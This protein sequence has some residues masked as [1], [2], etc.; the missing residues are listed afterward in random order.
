[1]R[2]FKKQ[3]F[4]M[5]VGGIF[6]CLLSLIGVSSCEKNSDSPTPNNNEGN[7]SCTCI[8]PE[9][10][11]SIHNCYSPD[12]VDTISADLRLSVSGKFSTESNPIGDSE[13]EER[14]LQ[15][16][17]PLNQRGGM[18]YTRISY[19]MKTC[20]SIKISLYDKDSVFIADVTDKAHFYYLMYK[21]NDYYQMLIN[22]DKVVLGKVRMGMTI[23]E[24]LE[25]KPFLFVNAHFIFDGLKKDDMKGGKF[26]KTEITLEDGTVLVANSK[27][28]EI[29]S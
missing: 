28:P 7:F 17:D 9:K 3:K 16:I 8:I 15:N 23:D 21:N 1:M 18:A 22:S 25:C 27:G 11:S 29:Y 6:I 2:N 19:T 12:E 4:L 5:S 26:F 10:V 24:Y 20:K 14:I 13:L